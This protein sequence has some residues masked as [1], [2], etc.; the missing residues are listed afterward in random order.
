MTSM[1]KYWMPLQSVAPG[2]S[3]FRVDDQAFWQNLL[4]EFDLDIRIAEP[5]EATVA[6]LPQ[7]EGVLFRGRVRGRVILPCDRCSGASSVE[8]DHSFDSFEPFPRDYAPVGTAGPDPSADAEPEEADEAVIRLGAHGRGIEINPAALAWEEFSLAL[9][10]K[11]L[12]SR[13]CKGLCPFCGCDRNAENCSCGE[14]EGD[15]RL[16]MLRGL[17]VQNKKK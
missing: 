14:G 12:C 2:G 15:P 5:V 13:D 3:E 9:P 1:D 11:P 4:D 8:L 16:A 7:A 6:V 10:L 17:T